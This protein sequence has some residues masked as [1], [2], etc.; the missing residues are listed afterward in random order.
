M[1]R[2]CTEREHHARP[3]G[4][5]YLVSAGIYMTTQGLLVFF[6]L[7]C[8]AMKVGVNSLGAGA[9]MTRVGGSLS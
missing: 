8:T 2:D 6:A 7:C 5:F 9:Q 1:R 3:V 4:A